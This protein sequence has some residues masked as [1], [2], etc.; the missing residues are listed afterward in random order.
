M[1]KVLVVGGTGYIGAAVVHALLA[2]GH[3]VVAMSRSGKS[4]HE[5]AEGRQGGL[6][7]PEVLAAAA[8]EADA[9]VH[10][11]APTGDE[12]VEA[13]A[14]DALSGPGRPFLYTSGIWSLGAT[15]RD[16]VDESAP[17][18]P[19]AISAFRPRVEQRVLA[20]GGTVIRPGIVY[21]HGA[22]IPAMLVGWA[23]EHGSGRYV[24]SCATRWPMVHVD[25]LADLFARILQSVEPPR[26]WHA[27]DEPAVSTVALAAA[28]DVAAG[29]PGTAER[30]TV[31]RAAEL[32]GENFATALATDQAVTS[33]HTARLGWAPKRS[34]VEDMASGSYVA[35]G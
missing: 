21:G 9:V 16:P 6:D 8:A 11:A 27:V 22:G 32:V 18:N 29:G 2:H 28:A 23:A 33:A 12:R 1:V 7:V 3:A 10:T 5:G 31:G 24:G 15:G 34:A 19:L 25:D 17:T 30:W 13:A 4:P 20:A 14:I 35:G 26:L